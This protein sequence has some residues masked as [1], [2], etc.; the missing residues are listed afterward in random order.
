MID[1]RSDNWSL[2]EHL[3]HGA[4][5]V[6]SILSVQGVHEADPRVCFHFEPI[7]WNEEEPWTDQASYNLRARPL[8]ETLPFSLNVDFIGGTSGIEAWEQVLPSLEWL[9]A[10]VPMLIHIADQTE[11][12]FAGWSFEPIAPRDFSFFSCGPALNV[13]NANT[14]EGKAAIDEL[15]ADA[16]VMKAKDT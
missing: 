14:A 10:R 15:I 12:L 1:Q 6:A 11:L 16:D 8:F 5:V 3:L 7:E 2:E 9:H 13:V 4:E